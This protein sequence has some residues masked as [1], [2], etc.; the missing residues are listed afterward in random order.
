MIKPVPS[1]HVRPV[2]VFIN[3]RSG[4]NQ[5]AKLMHKF[6]WLLN[7]RQV[8]DMA[9][10]EPSFALE[11]FRKVPNLRI[12]V[13]GGD[14]TAGWVLSTIDRLGISPCPPVAI[15]P[16]GTGN[17]LARTLN[18]GAGYTDEPLSKI[19]CCVEE[20]RVVQLDRWN[21]TVEP[22]Q[23][24]QQ[25]PDPTDRSTGR[26]YL[27]V[28][29]NYF[30]LGAD[31]AVA[32]EFHE[33]REA[34][35]ERFN[36]RLRNIMFY[37]GEGSRSIIKRPWRELSQV[38]NLE[39]DSVNMTDRIRELRVNSILFLN[40]PKYS[41]G[42]MPWG[43]PTG[44]QGFEPQR[45]DDGYVEVI[46]FSSSHLATVQMGWHGHRIC[47]C[48]R[49]IIRTSRIIPI[50]FNNLAIPLCVTSKTFENLSDRCNAPIVIF[51]KNIFSDGDYGFSQGAAPSSQPLIMER[52]RIQVSVISMTDY[53]SLQYDK[54]KLRLASYPLGI[55]LVEVDSDLEHVRTHIDRLA[56]DTCL[57]TQTGKS[58]LSN[59][60]VFLD[61]TTAERFFRI[62]KQQESLHFITDISSED[63][64]VLD[65]EL[66]T[67]SS[68]ERLFPVERVHSEET[69]P[70]MLVHSPDIEVA[71][72][73]DPD[74][75]CSSSEPG[76]PD[77]DNA[78]A[79][80]PPVGQLVRRRNSFLS[81]MNKNLIEACK[82]GSLDKMRSLRDEG[83][84]LCAADGAGMTCLHHATRFGY[85]DI[86]A[87]LIENGPP[88]LLDMIDTEK[89]QTALHKASWYQRRQICHLLV[90]A[91]ASLT[92]TDFSGLT[93]R[94]QAQR[95]EDSELALW[96]E[97]QEHMQ[98]VK[99]ENQETEV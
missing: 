55:I 24:C 77:S 50:Q 92:I 40:I 72:S 20:G 60:W 81:A 73:P 9:Q 91:G 47:Q 21:I 85:K 4:G 62:D 54:E 94:Q 80:G 18:W 86:V 16:L 44:S 58:R 10:H 57:I 67:G 79:V 53:E 90:Q 28:F 48:K 83:A 22:N 6:L 59:N 30:S 19:L 37:A 82:R 97:T 46:G 98:L 68:D 69:L 13:C 71:A 38:V 63:L 7:P 41:A 25:E 27:S 52:L 39:C 32:L 64:Y 34:N 88:Q 35:P 84:D 87:Y 89:G 8:F 56:S 45:P 23:D 75:R 43:N 36:S 33:S 14:G 1:P 26:P 70:K 11:L 95:A 3:P 49:A 93:P 74:Y 42:A 65:P 96:L 29:N 51:K 15:L 76:S 61:S 99:K 78:A 17:D 66:I 2:L 5:G 12:L 31:A